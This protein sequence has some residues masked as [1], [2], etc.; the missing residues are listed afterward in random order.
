[1]S[2]G[3]LNHLEQFCTDYLIK[4]LIEQTPPEFLQTVHKTA[5]LVWVHQPHF[6]EFA[7]VPV[8]L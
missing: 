2:T 1:M 7:R 4:A 6:P 8:N 3:N 5:Q